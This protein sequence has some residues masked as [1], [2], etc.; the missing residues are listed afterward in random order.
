LA[1]YLQRKRFFTNQY[2]EIPMVA[3]LYAGLRWNGELWGPNKY[4]V[5]TLWCQK[6]NVATFYF[7]IVEY[8]S[9]LDRYIQ[10][11]P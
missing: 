1:Q 11:Q 8:S 7:K 2:Q 4:H 9:Y 3:M 5:C 10:G 6:L